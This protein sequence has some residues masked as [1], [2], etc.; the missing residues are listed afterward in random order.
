MC[1]SAALHH[2]LQVL[3]DAF[4][5]YQTR[6]KLSHMG[7]IYYEGKVGQREQRGLWRR[8]LRPLTGCP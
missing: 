2:S 1:T 8:L 4:F 7:E 6:P 3:H 5:K